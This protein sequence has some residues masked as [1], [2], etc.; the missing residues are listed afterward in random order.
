MRTRR[1]LFINVGILIGYLVGWA[2]TP[3]SAAASGDSSANASAWRSMLGLGAVPPALILIGLVWLPESPRYLVASGQPE[4]AAA[5]LQRIYTADEAQATL[6]TLRRE[7]QQNKSLSLGAGLRRVFLPARGAPREMII[8][9]MGCAFW[10]Q[11]T[12]VEAVRA[13]APSHT[14]GPRSTVRR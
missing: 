12:G 7:R 1:S 10:Q 14:A 4:R 2:L 6:E 8:G 11:A 13:T 5:V 3:A 9:G